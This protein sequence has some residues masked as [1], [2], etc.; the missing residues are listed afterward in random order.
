MGKQTKAERLIMTYLNSGPWD[1][2][3]SRDLMIRAD[4]G[5]VPQEGIWGVLAVQNISAVVGP[6]GFV[7]KLY[8]DCI[9]HK[10]EH[11]SIVCISGRAAAEDLGGGSGLSIPLLSTTNSLEFHC[12]LEEPE[13]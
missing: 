6:K 4:T 1:P 7:L 12:C 2:L 8:L 9:S 13:S 10:I 3:L 11:K 5:W